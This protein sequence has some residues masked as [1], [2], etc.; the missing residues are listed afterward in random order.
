M[1]FRFLVNDSNKNKTFTVRVEADRE[2]IAR[3]KLEDA[4]YRPIAMVGVEVAN[5]GQSQGQLFIQVRLPVPRVR[6][7]H[8]P[9]R[10][11]RLRARLSSLVA[12]YLAPFSLLS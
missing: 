12:D 5:G 11:F 8:T 2:N 4:G 9:S 3:Q 6:L 1:S 10:V 7:S